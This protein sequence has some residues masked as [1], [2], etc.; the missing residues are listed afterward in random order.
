MVL[1]QWDY[2]SNQTRWK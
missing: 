1:Q 2:N